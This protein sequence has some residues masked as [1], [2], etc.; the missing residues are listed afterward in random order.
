MNYSLVAA[1][2]LIVLLIVYLMNSGVQA[3]EGMESLDTPNGCKNGI[4]IT[5]PKKLKQ[6]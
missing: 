5:K 4:C 2:V 1:I 6:D 3:A